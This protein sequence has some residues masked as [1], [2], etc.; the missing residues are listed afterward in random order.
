MKPPQ[1]KLVKNATP[2][3]RLDQL[4]EE[5]KAEIWI[6]RDDLTG[7][8]EGGNKVRKAQHLLTDALYQGADTII[9]AG[10][11]QSNHSRVIATAASAVGFDCHLVL[12]GAEPE[13]SIGNLLLDRLAGATLHFVSSGLVR[14]ARM[15]EVAAELR[16]RGKKPYIVPIGGSNVIGARG[17]VEAFRE[18]DSQLGPLPS[19]PSR[20]YFA[21]SSGGTYG[22]L[23]AGRAAC[24]SS[25]KLEAVRVDDDLYPEDNVL[26]VANALA[27]EMSLEQRFTDSDAPFNNGHVG[28]GYGVPSPEGIEALKLLWR[29]EGILLDP[30]YTAKA[31]AALI[32]DVRA[33]KLQGESAIFLHTG[34]QPSVYAAPT[35]WFEL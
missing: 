13:R 27:E 7:F 21:T 6:K 19:A 33:G 18:I 15:G 20:L 25:V 5:L 26:T 34:G 31:M 14:A 29:L 17:Y 9:T 30:V 24:G 1:I 12:S 22:G 11:V 32:S 4:S 3:H 28:E 8:S 35:A 16:S 10:A 2:F 23:L